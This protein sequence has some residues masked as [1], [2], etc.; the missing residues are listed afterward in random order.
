[1][2]KPTST[3]QLV[4]KRRN[5]TKDSDFQ[6]KICVTT[7]EVHCNFQNSDEFM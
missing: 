6:T 3:M 5:I 7:Q 2:L 4:S 1:M